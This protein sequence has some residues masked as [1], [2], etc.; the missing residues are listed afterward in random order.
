MESKTQMFN[1]CRSID[2]ARGNES[3]IYFNNL[4]KPIEIYNYVRKKRP[5]TSCLAAKHPKHCKFAII[6]MQQ[7]P[8]D[9]FLLYNTGVNFSSSNNFAHLGSF[10]KVSVQSLIPCSK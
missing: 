7:K 5:F 3:I 2:Y 6:Y 4:C 10:A 1:S 9:Y 8:A